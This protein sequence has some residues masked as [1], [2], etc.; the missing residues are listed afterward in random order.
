MNLP[1][2]GYSLGYE[3]FELGQ[4]S[5]RGLA[6]LEFERAMFGHGNTILHNASRAFKRRFAN[7]S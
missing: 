7:I 3:D 2:L 6:E 4:K 1:F 5:A